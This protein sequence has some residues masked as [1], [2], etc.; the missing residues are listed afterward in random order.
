MNTF[1][2]KCGE[3]Q[4][5]EGFEYRLL[6]NILNQTSNDCE[7]SWYSE[8]RMETLFRD[9]LWWLSVLVIIF[10][11]FICFMLR[12]R[13]FRDLVKFDSDDPGS[14]QESKTVQCPDDDHHLML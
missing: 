1:N 12:K 5:E 6:S 10:I 14:Q 9:Q 4:T 7:Q 3:I 8:L 13:F 11:I 2:K